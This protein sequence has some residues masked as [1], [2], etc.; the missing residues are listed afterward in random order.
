MASAGSPRIGSATAPKLPERPKM[1]AVEVTEPAWGR[2][3]VVIFCPHRDR[4]IR[5][6]GLQW[7]LLRCLDGRRTLAE[8]ERDFSGQLPSGAIR[9]LLV[10]FAQL[11]LLEDSAEDSGRRRDCRLRASDLTRIQLC[12]GNPD[13]LL[14][15][16]APLIRRLGGPVGRAVSTLVVIAGL[17]S[18]VTHADVAALVPERLTEPIWATTLVAA[19][20]LSS[21]LHEFGHAAAVKHFGGRVR[22]MGLMLFYLV[23]AMFCDASDAWRFPHRRQRAMVA[24]AGIWVQMIIA[25]LAQIALWLPVH[26][27]AAAWL[28]A[29]ALLNIALCVANLIPF[30]PLDGYWV[31]VAL[32]DVPHLRSR[33]LDGLKANVFRLVTGTIRPHEPVGGH[34]ILTMMFGLGCL[35]FTPL[36]VLIVLI[37]YRDALLRFGRPGAAVWLMLAA[38]VAAVPRRG[39]LRTVWSARRWPSPARRRAGLVSGAAL[40]AV[41]GALSVVKVP[42]SVQ[43]RYEVSRGG[44]VVAVL[45]AVTGRHAGAGDRIQLRAP[46]TSD[47]AFITSGALVG[48][49]DSSDQALRYQVTL[50]RPWEAPLSATG[51]VSVRAGKVTVRTWLWAAYL[52]PALSVL[53]GT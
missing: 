24:L 9:P 31:L 4:Y 13:R 21:A 17:Y 25:G 32:T 26:A 46:S 37:D 51:L 3:Y 52:G 41:A 27:D 34:P 12:L 20:L 40:V 11:G 38:G 28:W 39:L 48:D 36:L 14:D 43:G 30:V 18:M 49:P 47:R 29:F 10:R 7:G 35:L 15:R 1:A 45:P 6:Q 8:L 2:E 16:L 53:K 44:E 50:D 5:I 19:L 22:R 42:M 33:A 23:P